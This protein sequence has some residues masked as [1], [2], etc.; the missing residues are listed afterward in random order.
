MSSKGTGLYNAILKLITSIAIAGISLYISFLWILRDMYNEPQLSFITEV[1][2]K[3][4]FFEIMVPIILLVLSY[5]A[6][7]D[8]LLDF[9]DLLERRK[10]IK[11]LEWNTKK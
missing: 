4:I 5:G 6:I 8:S 7:R 11:K 3:S 9:F 1:S 2:F 10:R